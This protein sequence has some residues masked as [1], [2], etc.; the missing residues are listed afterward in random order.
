IPPAIAEQLEIDAKYRSY[1][2]RQDADVAAYR[3]DEALALP[4]DLAYDRIG[5]LSAEVREKLEKARPAT[6]GAAARIPGMT[7]AAVM[8]LLL[9]VRRGGWRRSA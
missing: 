3:K 9:H 5:G 1:V 4:D 2:E 8:A 7:P 6:L